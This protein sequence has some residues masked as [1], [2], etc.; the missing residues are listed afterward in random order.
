MAPF[1]NGTVAQTKYYGANVMRTDIQLAPNAIVFLD[2]LCYA[3]GNGEPGMPIPSWDIAHQRADNFAAG[4]LASGARTVFA[5]SWQLYIKALRDLMTTDKT[6]KQIFETPGAY[7]KAYY[8]WI[9]SDARMVDSVRTPGTV[10]YM[11]PDPK[12]GFLRTVSGDLTMTAGQWRGEEST[13]NLKPITIPAVGPTAPSQLRGT[14]YNGR[15][16]QLTWAAATMHH[17]GDVRYIVVRNNKSVGSWTTGTYFTEQLA[18]PGTYTYSVRAVDAAGVK[19]PLSNGVTVNVADTVGATMPPSPTPSPSSSS[20][21]SPTPTPTAAR[22]HRRPRDTEPTPTSSP[23][24]TPTPT[25]SGTPTPS[26]TPTASPVNSTPPTTPTGLTAISMTARQVFLSWQ[27]SSDDFAGLVSY[28]VF[29]DSVLVAT[30]TDTSF[31]DVPDTAGRFVYTV[32][33]IDVSG[34]KS[35]MSTA[36]NGYAFN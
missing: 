24:P 16:V 20:S 1:A 10:N 15:F 17:Y 33:A 18:K 2:H 31:I 36:V 30:V 23:T 35:G 3:A 13:A 21:P 8:G 5:Y 14:A 28:K 11:D 9:G 26:P 25:P 4:F 29:R 32:K 22:Q 12:D 27:P 6:M 34:N 7:P 19:G